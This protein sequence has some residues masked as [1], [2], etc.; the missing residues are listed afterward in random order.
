MKRKKQLEDFIEY[1]NRNNTFVFQK[2]IVMNP[3]FMIE[4]MKEI[5]CEQVGR[6]DYYQGFKLF[7]D[8]AHPVDALTTTHFLT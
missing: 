2:G 5:A 6:V 7:L 8:P 1:L 3:S 4:F